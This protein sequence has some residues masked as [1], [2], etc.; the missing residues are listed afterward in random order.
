M[1]TFEVTERWKTTWPGAVAGCLIV[2]GVANPERSDALEQRVEQIETSVRQRYAGA[3]RPTL[4]SQPP[5]DA[6]ARYYKRFGQNYH[7]LHQVESV[8]LKGKPIPRRAALVEAAFA[9]EVAS[10]LLTAMHDAAM[11]G[12]HIVTDAALGTEAMT[13]PNGTSV[14]IDAD[15]MY[16]RDEHG[17]LT[18]VIRGPAAYGLVRPQTTDLAVCVYAPAGIGVDAVRTH[19]DAILANVRLIAPGANLELIETVEA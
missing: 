5:F 17:T 18:S 11:I 6:Y 9:E 10:G 19:L 1:R 8:A 4:R 7:V 13:R 15:D 2:T 16:M 12:S 14:T 3:D